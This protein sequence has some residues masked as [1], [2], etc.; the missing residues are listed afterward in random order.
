MSKDEIRAM[1]ADPKYGKDPAFTMKV[2]KLFEKAF[3]GEYKPG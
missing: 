3:P 2:E 1:V